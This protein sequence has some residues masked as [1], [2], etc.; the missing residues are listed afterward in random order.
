MAGIIRSNN[1]R[2][3]SIVISR[4]VTSTV[5]LIGVLI[6]PIFAEI[7]KDVGMLMK[8]SPEIFAFKDVDSGFVEVR[9][10]QTT[11]VV[12]FAKGVPFSKLPV[13]KQSINGHRVQVKED[14]LV[15]AQD[16]MDTL[17]ARL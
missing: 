1:P 3:A 13:G 5:P 7:E 2:S 16:A 6:K 8:S 4:S 15:N 10:F 14:Y 11:G 17:V 9:D 12:A